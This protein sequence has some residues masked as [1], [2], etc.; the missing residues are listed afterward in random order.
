MGI[1]DSY[2]FGVMDG[3]GLYGREASTLL[4]MRLP[5]NLSLVQSSA[6]KQSKL[7][8]LANPSFRQH[9]FK[10]AYEKTNVEMKGSNFDPS[11]SGSTSIT[12]FMHN[13]LLVCANIGDS[14]AII[15]SW[16]EQNG[17]R[18]EQ[19]SVDHKPETKGEYERIVSCNGRVEACRGTLALLLD[20]AGREVG[21]RRVWMKTKNRPGLAMSRS[22]GDAVASKI[23]V[24]AVPDVF[25]VKA[26]E[27]VKIVIV[28]SDGLWGVIG[29][30]KA[31]SIASKHHKENEAQAACEEL[32]EEATK[33][34][35]RL[36]E[37]VDDITVIVVFLK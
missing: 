29:N 37:V 32:V 2:L 36:G 33:A 12:V 15:G 17:W 1:E 30:E 6:R 16:S 26:A 7:E 19:V 24:I 10:K 14:R 5:L 13:S 21:P 25:E 23:G 8:F 4:R 3:H 28:A 18:T 11:Y 9:V 35:N 34:W 20:G 22:L 31:M 27:E